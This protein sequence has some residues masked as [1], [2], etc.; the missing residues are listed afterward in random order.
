VVRGF[1]VRML[2]ENDPEHFSRLLGVWRTIVRQHIES[3]VPKPAR[4]RT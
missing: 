3:L 2:I 1:S 4:K